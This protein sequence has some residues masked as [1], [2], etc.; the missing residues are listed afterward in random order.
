MVKHMN[1][2]ITMQ[3][4]LGLRHVI[5]DGIAILKGEQFAQQRRDYVLN[6]L[7]SLFGEVVRGSA[8]V[9]SPSLF[10]GREDKRAFEAFS[11]LDRFLPSDDHAVQET[12]KLS[13][14]TLGEIKSGKQVSSEQS[15]KLMNF[16]MTIVSS[17]RRQD[18]A[19]VPN[20]PETR[21]TLGI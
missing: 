20:Q 1:T 16:L 9:H 4:G 19:G 12:L 3:T 21:N 2:E 11:L 8:L 14:D 17:L 13:A 18:S 5:E 6:D 7:Q 15:A 10:I